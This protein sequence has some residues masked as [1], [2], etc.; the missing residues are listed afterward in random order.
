MG[1][2]A[3]DTVAFLVHGDEDWH[4]DDYWTLLMCSLRNVIRLTMITLRDYDWSCR[5][6]QVRISDEEYGSGCSSH[7]RLYPT[8]RKESIPP[9][10][11]SLF[12]FSISC[13]A[14]NAPIIIYFNGDGV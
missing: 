5:L 11:D 10:E 14:S 9:E 2:G 12:R 6:T 13:R 8:A 4:Y 1:R 7:S 3:A